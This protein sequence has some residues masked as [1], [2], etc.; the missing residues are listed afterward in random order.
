MI[1]LFLWLTNTTATL[2]FGSLN[3]NPFSIDIRVYLQCQKVDA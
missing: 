3:N 2:V 1:T